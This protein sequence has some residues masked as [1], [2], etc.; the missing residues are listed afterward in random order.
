MTILNLRKPGVLGLLRK[1][2]EVKLFDDVDEAPQ[3]NYNDINVYALQD[4][5]IGNSM[6]DVDKHFN[7]LFAFLGHGKTKEALQKAKNMYQTFYYML[8]RIDFNALQFGCFIHSIDGVEVTDYSVS[9]IQKMIS[10]L[11]ERGLTH[12]MIIQ[13]VEALKKNSTCS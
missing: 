6:A 1:P 10:Y 8:E 9:N 4:F 5:E 3:N 2:T 12:G 11:S 13:Q 7:Q